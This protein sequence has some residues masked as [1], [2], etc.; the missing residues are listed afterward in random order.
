MLF[1]LLLCSLSKPALLSSSARQCDPTPPVLRSSCT[2]LSSPPLSPH[3]SSLRSEVS[4]SSVLY[5][6]ISS[7]ATS[8]SVF[9]SHFRYSSLSSLIPA[10][11]YSFH[12]LSLSVSPPVFCILPMTSTMISSVIHFTPLAL[13]SCYSFNDLELSYSSETRMTHWWRMCALCPSTCSFLP[14]SLT[15]GSAIFA[16][17]LSIHHRNEAAAKQEVYLVQSETTLLLLLLSCK[18]CSHP[19]IP[20][21]KVISSSG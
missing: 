11:S 12:S 10:S 3:S 20:S 5:P 8:P 4:F 1:V 2:L 16:V 6:L 17:F 9:P 13:C 14:S 15:P 18:H 21:S 19:M 7:S